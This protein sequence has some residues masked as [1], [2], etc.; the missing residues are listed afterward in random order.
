MAEPMPQQAGG[1]ILIEAR[2]LSRFFDV[3]A[4]LLNRLA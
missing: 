2:N 1:D 3:S 4:P